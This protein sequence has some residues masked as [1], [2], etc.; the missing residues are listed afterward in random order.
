M[1]KALVALLILAVA[2]GVFAQDLT[3]SGAVDTGL[4]IAIP[5]GD[6]DPYVQLYHDDAGPARVRLNGAFSLDN[7]GLKFRFQNT[8]NKSG[9]AVVAAYAFVYANFL[10][11]ILTLSAG[12]IDGNAWGTPGD[13]DSGWDGVTGARFEI[14]PIEGL[15]FGFA[16]KAVAADDKLYTISQ[17]FQETVIGVKYDSDLFTA[18]AAVQLDSDADAPDADGNN[19]Y[20]AGG[21]G[22]PDEL[23][24][25][26]GVS[27]KAVP[28]LTAA[29]DG[30][31]TNLGKYDPKGVIEIH[32]KLGYAI[33]DP[34]NVGLTMVQK[35]Y[36]QSDKDPYLK[37]DPWVS[38]QINDPLKAQLDI[39]VESSNV[40]EDI[41]IGIKPKI[42]YAIG[43][44]AE[45]SAYWLSTFTTGDVDPPVPH[46]LQVNFG[47]S[48]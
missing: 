17:F 37:F 5:S 9:D 3:F 30:A 4:T 20:V 25:L 18:V 11:D 12:R 43:E 42:V 28:N 21:N 14:K 40:F 6:D 48:F 47:W 46:K 32:E 29:I 36:G 7:Y 13:F 8:Y 22:D 16:L 34:L 15:N 10:N 24:I 44:K 35:L 26:Y 31:V 45:L 39:I 33:S 27:I 2:G 23:G 41:D 1:K 38:Y 19:Q